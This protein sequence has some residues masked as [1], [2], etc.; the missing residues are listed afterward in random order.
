[1]KYGFR[2]GRFHKGNASRLGKLG[3]EAKAKKRMEC[4]RDPEPRRVPDGEL[5]YTIQIQESSG[6]VRRWVINQ[7]PRAN[8]IRVKAKGREVVCGWD[9]LMRS[10]RHNLSIQKRIFS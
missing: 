1:M 9:H 7:G 6:Q 10:L 4:P 5:L 3:V 8:N 2:K